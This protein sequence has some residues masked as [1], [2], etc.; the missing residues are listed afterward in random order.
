M[1]SWL[2]LGAVALVGFVGCCSFAVVLAEQKFSAGRIAEFEV[3][4]ASRRADTRIKQVLRAAENTAISA[5]RASGPKVGDTGTWHT[6]F[7]ALMPAF[8]QRPSLTY[9]GFSLARTGEAALLHRKPDGVIEW[10]VYRDKPNGDRSLFSYRYQT[11]EFILVSEVPWDGWDPRKRPYY[12]VA[13]EAR[14]PAWTEAYL[15]SDPEG[16]KSIFGVTHVLPVYDKNGELLGVW[17][18]DFDARSLCDA[19][20]QFEADLGGLTFIVET[21]V[22]GKQ[23]L[24]GHP[25]DEMITGKELPARSIDDWA[26]EELR[27]AFGESHARGLYASVALEPP[28]PSWTL[29]TLIP[30]SPL[31]HRHYRRQLLLFGATI[32][33]A[34]LLAGIGCLFFARRMARPVEA[35]RAAVD[36]LSRGGS[37]PPFVGT[38]PREMTELIREFTSLMHSVDERQRQLAESKQSLERE[39]AERTLREALLS[40][41]FAH[42]PFELWVVDPKGRVLLQ[43]AASKQCLG[44][45]TGRPFEQ[46]A[47]SRAWALAWEDSLARACRGE[48][49]RIEVVEQ[50]EMEPHYLHALLAGV[51]GSS[52][53]VGN[54]VCVCID[55]TEK[56]R[57][58]EALLASQRRLSIHL[59]NTPLGV[60]EWTPDLVVTAWNQ[61]AEIIFGWPASEMLGKRANLITTETSLHDLENVWAELAS[62]KRAARHYCQN[63][64]RDGRM[65]DCEW[66]NTVVTDPDGQVSGIS[67][68]VLDVSERVRAELMFR[69]SEERFQKAFRRAPVA[70]AIV[71]IADFTLLDVNDRWCEVFGFS[72]RHAVGRTETELGLW[73][74]EQAKY[75]EILRRLNKQ[76]EI[77]DS[78]VMQ[79]G[80][81][82]KAGTYLVSITLVTLGSAPAMIVSHVDISERKRAEEEIRALNEGLEKRVAER[83]EELAKANGRLQELDRLKS[84]FLATMSHELRTPLNAIIGFSSILRLKMAGPLSPEQMRQVDLILNSARHLLDL[85]NDILDLSRIEAGRFELMPESFSLEELLAQVEK[86][87]APMVASKGLAYNTR[88]PAD[89]PLMHTDRKRVLQIILNLANNA[90]KFTERG[91]VSVE[92]PPMSRDNAVTI[93]VKD[94]GIGIKAES[95]PRLFEA[96]RQVD[97]SARRVFEGTGL[98]LYL[99]RKLLD[100]L[101]GTVEVRSTFGSG[102]VFTVTI[103]LTLA[104]PKEGRLPPRGAS[105]FAPTEK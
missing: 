38:A 15:F 65:I 85:I 23:L 63:L 55:V 72:R 54:V 34:T 62:G 100:M 105:H 3:A 99:V 57:A 52:G 93:S 86:T 18:C 8:E 73:S 83:T 7:L 42:V 102:S 37:V 68:L 29:I 4:E 13:A 35:L 25:R 84:E 50:A 44:D 12:Q 9:L 27:R 41:V 103:P 81:D 97:G 22:G 98:G 89:V 36:S 11:G 88:C 47:V 31:A 61:A 6:L 58:E 70:Q 77:R 43:S 76:G 78:E 39:V 82:G 101:G 94:T 71:R 64:T 14:K 87:L 46:A 32:L 30:E 66:Y 49:V 56:R 75:K 67:S 69:E 48:I 45:L 95:L 1:R 16:R 91:E 19:M 10:L 24:L 51:P 17:D 79:A 59:E 96:F 20:R 80:A 60:I 5:W 2:L 28:F 92:V 21:R 33:G 53:E 104:H 74:L 90:V 40:A 26:R